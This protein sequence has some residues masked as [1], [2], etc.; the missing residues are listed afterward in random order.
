MQQRTWHH[1]E[2]P[3]GL[4]TAATYRLGCRCDDCGAA[5]RAY[6]A[7]YRASRT[8]RNTDG[9]RTYHTHVGQP[10]PRTARK[11]RC[12]HPRCLHL[13]GLYLDHRGIVRHAGTGRPADGFTTT[14]AAS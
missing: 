4:P 9:T 1:S 11:Y 12:T 2:S 13:A 5:Y 8:S 3:D 14:A 7:A 6:L 10:S